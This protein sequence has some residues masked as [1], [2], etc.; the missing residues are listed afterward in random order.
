MASLGCH[1]QR[2]QLL[3]STSN[4]ASASSTG[5]EPSSTGT[6][7]S[8]TGP[9]LSSTGPELSSTGTKP[10][11]IGPEPS[12]T[13][14]EPSLIGPESP[15][16]GPEPSTGQQDQNLQQQDKCPVHKQSQLARDSI[17]WVCLQAPSAIQ[18]RHQH[19]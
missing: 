1:H 19:N 3:L 7:L 14:T 5:P 4:T 15:S 2:G 11:L 9:E 13:G 18:S 8:S 17:G 12:S 10:S 16:T 6:E